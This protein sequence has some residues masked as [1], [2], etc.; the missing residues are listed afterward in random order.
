MFEAYQYIIENAGIDTAKVYPYFEQV[1]FTTSHHSHC[2]MYS[3][4][5]VDYRGLFIL[6]QSYCQYV[7]GGSGAEI[8]R[9]IQI[10]SGSEKDLQTALAYVG[11]IAVAVDASSTAFRVS[12]ALYDMYL[13]CI[14]QYIVC[15]GQDYT[16]VLFLSHI[17]LIQYYSSGVY[18]SIRCSR[19]I[20]NHA[21]LVTGFGSYNGVDYYLVKN[22]YIQ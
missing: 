10:A 19:T 7:S 5:L 8:T 18:S 20:L 14:Y 11:P 2:C 4:R 13:S 21:M 17:F 16:Q 12:I 22:R 9:F 6:Q 1:L 15:N 3:T